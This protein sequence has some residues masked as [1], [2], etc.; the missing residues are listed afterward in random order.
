MIT[1][2]LDSDYSNANLAMLLY[3]Q[4]EDANKPIS[5][6]FGVP[7]AALKPALALYDTIVQLKA[8]GIKVTTVAHSLCAGMGAFLVASGSPGRRFATPNAVF[9]MG[10]HGLESPI[11]GQASEIEVEARQMLREAA[12]VEQE[13]ANITGRSLEQ[14]QKDLKRDFYLS[15]AQAAE[16]GLVDRVLIPQT[17][18]GAKLDKG[19]RDPFSGQV[20]KE[21]VGFGVFADQNQP[22]TAIGKPDGKEMS[23]PP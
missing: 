13:L 14:I 7:G 4:S 11:Q 8:K 9:Q 23:N 16:Y 12:C 2:F 19:T 10:K 17:D 6:Y 21:K 3:L 20:T 22:R 1:E 18:K 5:I 15:A